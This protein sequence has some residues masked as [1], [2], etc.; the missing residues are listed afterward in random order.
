M[1][2]EEGKAEGEEVR[3]VK[4]ARTVEELN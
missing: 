1:D 3:E 4:K 2:I